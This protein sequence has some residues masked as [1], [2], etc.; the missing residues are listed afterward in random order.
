MQIKKL[1]IRN[2][3]SFKDVEISGF[4][5][6]NLITGKNNSGKSTLLE[7]LRIFTSDASQRVLDDILQQRQEISDQMAETSRGEVP[8]QRFDGETIPYSC[9]FTDIP[10]IRECTLGFEIS[11]GDS[12]SINGGIHRSVKVKLCLMGEEHFH[13]RSGRSRWE[14]KHFDVSSENEL[15][16]LSSTEGYP[17]IFII[18]DGTIQNSY[19]L[20][21]LRPWRRLYTVNRKAKSIYLSANSEHDDRSIYMLWDQIALTDYEAYVIEALQVVSPDIEQIS[22]IAYD[23]R[24]PSSRRRVIVRSSKFDEPVSLKSYGD[25]TGRIFN[26]IISL[27]SARNGYL[28]IDEIENGIHYSALKSLWGTVFLLAE[29]LDVQVFAT[30]HSLDCVKSFELASNC[31][32]SD[33]ALL[34]LVKSN[35][36]IIPT[37]FDEK[38]LETAY[39]QDIELR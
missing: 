20:M 12:N 9:L 27:I 32:D 13:D 6:V 19:P 5:K 3:K 35:K 15:D 17:V 21:E 26:L 22:L 8:V 25:G 16:G 31:S 10:A 37:I 39:Y 29:K 11:A 28:F 23:S 2:F 24:A 1:G 7:A 18:I 38:E 4:G 34:R 30:T 36:K 33:G 14:A